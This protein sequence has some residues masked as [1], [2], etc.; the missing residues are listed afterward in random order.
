MYRA[1]QYG[2]LSICIQ[3]YDIEGHTRLPPLRY[4]HGKRGAAGGQDRAVSTAGG[5]LKRKH[6]PGKVLSQGG[7]TTPLS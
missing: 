7:G 1:I 2:W 4:T 5:L 6:A 3:I